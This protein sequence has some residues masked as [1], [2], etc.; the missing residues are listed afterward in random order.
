MLN[1]NCFINMLDLTSWACL[2]EYKLRAE[3]I[4]KKPQFML[5]AVVL[6][7]HTK[8]QTLGWNWDCGSVKS[9]KA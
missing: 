1:G 2:P 4:R 3:S 9:T 7:N 8:A 6:G 5:P